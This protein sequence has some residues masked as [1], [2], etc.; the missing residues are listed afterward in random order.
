MSSFD[1]TLTIERMARRLRSRGAAHPVAGAVALAARGSRRLGADDF[2]V[3]MGLLGDVVRSAERGDV[4]L[5]S[6]PTEIGALAF[7]TGADLLA[8]TDL[9]RQWR[10]DPPPGD[11][12]GA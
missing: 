6:L 3:E 12:V 1:P 10:R 9:E 8:L 7:A 5:G 4:P 2:A 11:V